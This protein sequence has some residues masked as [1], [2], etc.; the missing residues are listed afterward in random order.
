MERLDS[1]KWAILQINYYQKVEL[2]GVVLTADRRNKH[3]ISG[4]NVDIYKYRSWG[5]L[6][7]SDNE[8]PLQV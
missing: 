6:R 1:L 7:D 5:N 2:I 8:S 4:E 3:T